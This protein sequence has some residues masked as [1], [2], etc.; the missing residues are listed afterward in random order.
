MRTGV[1][2]YQPAS[3][4][5]PAPVEAARFDIRIEST[6]DPPTAGKNV[7]NVRLLD[8]NAQPVTDAEIQVRFHMAAMPSMNMPAMGTEATLAHVSNGLY[9]GSAFLSMGGSW[10]VTIVARRDGRS[11]AERHTSLLVR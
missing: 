4:E 3:S 7:V 1:Q 10:S 8:A 6:P 5:H 2:N 11:I 9:R